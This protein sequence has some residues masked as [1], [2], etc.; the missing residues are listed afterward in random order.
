MGDHNVPNALLFIDKYSQIYR[1]LLPITNVLSHIVNDA[2]VRDYAIREW[3]GTEEAIRLVLVD[4]FRSAFDGS[5][6]KFACAR[7]GFR[8]TFL[9]W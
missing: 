5:G 1:I 4:F 7:S 2:R 6:G 8:L 9:I 3:G